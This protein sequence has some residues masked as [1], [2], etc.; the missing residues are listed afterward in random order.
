MI[1]VNF[2]F[3][4]KSYM[5]T[6]SLLAITCPVCINFKLFSIINTKEQKK[7]S[8]DQ[9]STSKVLFFCLI[10]GK[11]IYSHIYI[12]IYYLRTQSKNGLSQ[13][14]F[15][16][17]S[18]S[19]FLWSNKALRHTLIQSVSYIC[20]L[21]SLF[22]SFVFFFLLACIPSLSLSLSLSHSPRFRHP[23]CPYWRNVY[24]Y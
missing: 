18:N 9:E 13:L 23:Q 14:P 5:H 20:M 2:Y 4:L 24:I 7:E 12:H 16:V 15:Q 21:I 22:F 19:K 17:K 10:W 3:S 8:F 1:K 6:Y 11:D